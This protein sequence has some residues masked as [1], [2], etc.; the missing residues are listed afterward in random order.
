MSIMMLIMSYYV[1]AQ[2]YNTTMVVGIFRAGG[3]AKF[4]LIMDVSTMWG[5]S[6]LLGA[7]FAFVFHWSVPAVYVVIMGD[8]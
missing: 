7:I 5:R 3:D 1:I 2:A 8:S 4:G 6:I